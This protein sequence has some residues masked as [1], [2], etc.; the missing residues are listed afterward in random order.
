[1]HQYIFE[2]E[3]NGRVLTESTRNILPIP[4]ID[5]LAIAQISNNTLFEYY[6]YLIFRPWRHT[7]EWFD[8][9]AVETF[10]SHVKSVIVNGL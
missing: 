1:M 6:L 4:I 3:S 8:K 7:G 9:L 2:N 5:V 10:L